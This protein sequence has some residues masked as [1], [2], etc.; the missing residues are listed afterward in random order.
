MAWKGRDQDIKA[1][2]NQLI[3]I[4]NNSRIQTENNALYQVIRNMIVNAQKNKNITV[5]EFKN[6]IEQIISI[7]GAITT[8]NNILG[9][10]VNATY[11]TKDN[12]TIPLP[13]SRQALAGTGITLDYTIPSQVTISTSG[14]LG[15]HYD[16]PLSDGDLIAAELI[17]AAGECIIVQVPV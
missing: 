15:N 2:F 9:S 1:D 16:S 4:L 8:I 6:L 17:F 7:D 5:K 13:F 3:Q 10:V 11:W 14:G 12:E